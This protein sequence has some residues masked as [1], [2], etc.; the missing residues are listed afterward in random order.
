VAEK[1]H[2]AVVKYNRLAYVSKLGLTAASRGSP[3]GSTA[4]VNLTKEQNN[5]SITVIRTK[6]H[7]K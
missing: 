4:L 5:E 1:A 3:C 2:Y 7:L 6:M